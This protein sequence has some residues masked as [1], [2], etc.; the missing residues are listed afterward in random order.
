MGAVAILSSP[1]L[2]E[3]DLELV[4]WRSQMRKFKGNVTVN[5]LA[6]IDFDEI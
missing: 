6:A 4:K 3:K 1:L 2:M 5:S